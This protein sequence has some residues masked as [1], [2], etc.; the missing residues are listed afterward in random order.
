MIERLRIEWT[1]WIE[2]SYWVLST[3]SKALCA[4]S[5]KKN[6]LMCC[7]KLCIKT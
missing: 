5:Y 7:I 2:R 6:A 3:F 4:V 1:L